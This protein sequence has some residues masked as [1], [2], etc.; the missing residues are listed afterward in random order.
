MSNSM[1]ASA[2]SCAC[3]ALSYERVTPQVS[4]SL[5]V[6]FIAFGLG[7]SSISAIF[8]ILTS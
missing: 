6:N 8:G 7:V 2:S 5:R 1:E 4:G 3:S